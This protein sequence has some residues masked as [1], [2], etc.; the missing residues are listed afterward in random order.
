MIKRVVKDRLAATLMR[1]LVNHGFS[2]HLID[3]TPP[4]STI[5]EILDGGGG[6]FEVVV[7]DIPSN[8]DCSFLVSVRAES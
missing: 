4:T 8:S 1:H 5:K 6:R 2:R 7:H 3:D